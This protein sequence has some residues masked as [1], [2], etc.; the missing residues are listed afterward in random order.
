MEFVVSGSRRY[1][2]VVVKHPRAKHLVG[3]A[4]DLDGAAAKAGEAD[5][6]RRYPARPEFGL[7]EV[8][9]F[10]V[11]SFGRLGP[12]AERLLKEARHRVVAADRRFTG[13]LGVALY[14]QWQARLSC[15]L[16]SGLW[17]GAAASWGF[18]GARSG[19]WE[20]VADLSGGAR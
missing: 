7:S 18:A 15:A 9:P 2:D 5:K 4:A 12:A 17:D 16:V 20:D 14:Q 3:S 1:V 13:W 11:E 8:V 10:A 6:R 19:L